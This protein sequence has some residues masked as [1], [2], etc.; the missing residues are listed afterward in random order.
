MIIEPCHLLISSICEIRSF[1]KNFRC[2][3]DPFERN[4]IRSSKVY[5]MSELEKCIIFVNKDNGEKNGDDDD[6]ERLE[7]VALG[8]TAMK[9]ILKS[10]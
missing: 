3:C 7:V 4:D 8:Y 10:R 9:I 1:R 2:Q 6:Y 5:N